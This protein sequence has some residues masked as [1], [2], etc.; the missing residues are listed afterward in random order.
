MPK[1]IPR[2]A[3]R[4]RSRRPFVFTPAR[5]AALDAARAQRRFEMTPAK[6]AAVR[7]A[8]DA[9]RRNFHLTPA[10][11]QAMSINGRKMQQASVRK[12]QMTDKRTRAN[13]ANMAKAWATKRPPESYARSRFNHLNH[14]LQVR[15]LDE[16]LRQLG[17]DPQALEKH[18][19]GFARVFAPT[20]SVEEKI[21]GLL[22]DAVWRRLR[23]F[24]AQAVWESETLARLLE[25]AL[26]IQP[27]D[28]EDTFLRAS[29]LMVLL[30]NRQRFHLRDQ[31]LTGVVE[32][33]LRALI[34]LRSGGKLKFHYLM[35]QSPQEKRKTKELE[36]AYDRY[37]KKLREVDFYDRLARGGPEVEAAIAK[38]HSQ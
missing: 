12:F 19:R 21:V 18:R 38:V 2:P 37:E 13:L 20:N 16:T 23:L 4:R 35:R 32:R 30:L 27:Y 6:W 17:D 9:N 3:R 7:K 1:T 26:P 28:A 22:A 34:H 25:V 33:E 15:N 36:E 31:G 11:L 29:G 14:G 5:R 8:V 10:R 24:K